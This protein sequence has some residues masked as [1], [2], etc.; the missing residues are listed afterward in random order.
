MLY[1]W[2]LNNRFMYHTKYI[3][4]GFCKIL[5]FLKDGSYAQQGCSYLNKNT[6]KTVKLLNII[7]I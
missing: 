2:K 3:K 7:T 5:Q 1:Y 4:F 6:V